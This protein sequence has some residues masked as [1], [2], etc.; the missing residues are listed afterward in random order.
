[1]GGRF[2][3]MQSVTPLVE[4]SFGDFREAIARLPDSEEPDRERLVAEP[5]VLGEVGDLQVV[6]APFDY[7]NEGARVMLVGVTPAPSI[8]NNPPTV[9]SAASPIDSRETSASARSPLLGAS[10]TDTLQP[11]SGIH[12]PVTGDVDAS[13]GQT[14][15]ATSSSSSPP[16]S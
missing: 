2:G 10:I 4:R 3:M 11:W 13:E 14:C 15:S 8:F 5:F 9:L 6:Y 12:A 1:M 7:V 16:S